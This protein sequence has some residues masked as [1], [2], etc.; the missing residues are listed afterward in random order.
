MLGGPYDLTSECWTVRVDS[1]NGDCVMGFGLR[2]DSR[3]GIDKRFGSMVK[4]EVKTS[5]SVEFSS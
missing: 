5:T 4:S 1:W 2:V 3:V